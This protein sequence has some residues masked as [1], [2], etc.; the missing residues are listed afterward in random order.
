MNTSMADTP[1]IRKEQAKPNTRRQGTGNY[2]IEEQRRW[3]TAAAGVTV[4][5]VLA[6]VFYL[7]RYVVL[8]FGVAAALAFLAAPLLRWLKRV[9]RWR[10][11]Q[12][13]LAVYVSYLVLFGLVG[14][15]VYRYVYP[16]FLSLAENLPN[17]LEHLLRVMFRSNTIHLL[18]TTISA[19]HLTQRAT[20][21]IRALAQN[22]ANLAA[23]GLIGISGLIGFFV[24]IAL[25]GYFLFQGPQLGNGLLWLMPPKHRRRIRVL[26]AEVEPVVYNYVRGVI[27]I[28]FYAM[29]VTGIVTGLV[30]H[31]PQPILLAIVVGLLESIPMVGP[32]LALILLG[33]VV[34]ER[35]T[36]ELLL[37]F[38]A[39]AAGL[40]LSIDNLLAPLVLGRYV[41]LP[42]PVII[43]AFLAGGVLF[44]FVGVLLAIP[45]AAAVKVVLADLYG[46]RKLISQIRRGSAIARQPARDK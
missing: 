33:L 3:M 26:A 23:A 40:R 4:I 20:A 39:F 1:T 12:A 34:A 41:M 36:P 28:V 11:W 9:R 32:A 37:G 44:G 14:I 6:F 42:P 5:L 15:G 13:A 45:I 43:F 16:E 2:A 46:D 22:P 10:H 30:L 38:A 17:L 31:L 35:A 21:E 7:L 19:Q 25:L 29:A 27:V 18:G 24:T 8:P